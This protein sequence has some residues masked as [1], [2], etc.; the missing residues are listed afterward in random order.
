MPRINSTLSMASRGPV[1]L[2]PDRA[3]KSKASGVQIL[4]VVL[5][6]PVALGK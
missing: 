1:N 3:F 5:P 6:M 4:V 2:I